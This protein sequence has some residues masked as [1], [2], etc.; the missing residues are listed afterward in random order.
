MKTIRGIERELPKKKA[1]QNAYKKELKELTE[2]K[3]LSILLGDVW[4][5]LDRD[6]QRLTD[7]VQKLDNEIAVLEVQY[8]KQSEETKNS[9]SP[10]KRRFMKIMK[11]KSDQRM[12]DGQHN[13]DW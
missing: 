11:K 3:R 12:Q 13:S 4:E 9:F 7:R 1:K 8:E 10:Q 6:L 2:I 5:G